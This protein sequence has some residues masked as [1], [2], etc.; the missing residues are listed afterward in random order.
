MILV[1]VPMFSSVSLCQWVHGYSLCLPASGSVYLVLCW[2]LW[3]IGSWILFRVVSFFR[4]LHATIQFDQHRVFVMLFLFQCVFLTS[5]SK[6]RCHR[7]VDFCLGLWF[8][9]IHHHVCFYLGP[10]CFITIAE[11]CLSK[12]SKELCYNFEGD[13]IQPAD[14]FL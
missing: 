2:S 11:N 1:P 4:F 5:V 8:D 7:C 10:C 9:S 6:I 3:S 13:C 12:V 14:C